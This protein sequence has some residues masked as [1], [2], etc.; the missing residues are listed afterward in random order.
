MKNDSNQVTFGMGLSPLSAF[1]IDVT[2][3]ISEDNT[4]GIVAQT[5][6]TF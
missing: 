1:N 3:M 6:F 4:Y 5:S 2:G